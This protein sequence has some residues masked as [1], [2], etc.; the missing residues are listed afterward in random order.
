MSE[1]K[2]FINVEQIDE[3]SEVHSHGH[4]HD[5]DHKEEDEHSHYHSCSGAE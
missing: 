4:G 5:E 3:N 2:Q 1:E